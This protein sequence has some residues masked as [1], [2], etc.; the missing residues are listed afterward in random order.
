MNSTKNSFNTNKQTINKFAKEES[1]LKSYNETFY[2]SLKSIQFLSNPL[3]KEEKLVYK[4][5][6]NDNAPVSSTIGQLESMLDELL[7]TNKKIKENMKDLNKEIKDLK[8]QVKNV[9]DD[10][11]EVYRP[12]VEKLKSVLNEF[13]ENQKLENERLNE[14][15]ILLEKEKD[16]IQQSIYDAL[17]YLHKLEK[18]VG[19]KSKTYTY[20]YD[21][22]LSEN[23]LSSKFI[24]KDEN[25]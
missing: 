10:N 17:G 2:T 5:E 24:I 13:I 23:E 8:D 19:I 6:Q 7:L 1:M 20:Y 12:E 3:P 22:T 18:Q 11:M 9:D 14:E 4:F 15:I 16:E 25:I 21:Q